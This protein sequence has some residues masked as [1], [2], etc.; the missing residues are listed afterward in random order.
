MNGL[1]W[2]RLTGVL[3]KWRDNSQGSHDNELDGRLHPVL[4]FRSLES[5]VGKSV[6]KMYQPVWLLW[7]PLSTAFPSHPYQGMNG[8]ISRILW[9]MCHMN[10][11][12]K[13]QGHIEGISVYVIV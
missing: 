8:K 2:V 1:L 12:V 10:T 6:N 13:G 9:W 5:G 7:F 11:K 4:R 3:H